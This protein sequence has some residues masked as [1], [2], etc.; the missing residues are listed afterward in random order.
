[1]N[2]QNCIHCCIHVHILMYT[3]LHTLM[4]NGSLS[5]QVTMATVILFCLSLSNPFTIVIAVFDGTI[6]DY[7]VSK[8]WSRSCDSSLEIQIWIKI[9]NVAFTQCHIWVPVEIRQRNNTKSE[10]VGLLSSVI[11]DV[12]SLSEHSR[13]RS[14]QSPTDREWSG[15]VRQALPTVRCIP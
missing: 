9:C 2:N 6:P 15:E 1:M 8:V 14:S 10:N 13:I 12:L 11:W 3:Y 4:S 5:L 7:N